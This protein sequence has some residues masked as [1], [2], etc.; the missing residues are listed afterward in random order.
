M[1]FTSNDFIFRGLADLRNPFNHYPIQESPIIG[2]DRKV[3][4][5]SDSFFFKENIFYKYV[6]SCIL[7]KVRIKLHAIRT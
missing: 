3:S 4:I 7:P 6:F 2:R 1:A 5:A